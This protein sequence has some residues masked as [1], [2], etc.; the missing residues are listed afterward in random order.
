MITLYKRIYCPYCGVE[1]RVGGDHGENKL[2]R[3]DNE[4]GGCD[5]VFSVHI[6][7]KIE[8]TT[9]KVFEFQKFPADEDLIKGREAA[10]REGK[11]E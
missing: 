6:F 4:I 5:Q 10:G 11:N 7:Y 3:C 1:Q 8:V 2:V 9:F